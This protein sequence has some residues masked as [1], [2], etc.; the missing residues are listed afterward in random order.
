MNALFHVEQAISLRLQ[1]PVNRDACP[2]SDEPADVLG[3]HDHFCSG[4]LEDMSLLP[5]VF[6]LSFQPVRPKLGRALI[7][8]PL[9]GGLFFVLKAMQRSFQVLQR[10]GEALRFDA[11]LA[12]RLVDKVNGLVRQMAVGDVAAAELH[13]R[14]QR[15]VLDLHFVVRLVLRPERPKHQQGVLVVR[16]LH[17]DGL[18]STLQRTV[19]FDVLPVLG[20]GGGAHALQLAPG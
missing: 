18:E 7:V 19:L 8:G 5:V 10:R 1:E 9:S 12:G 11:F 15:G 17:E 4:V 6:F 3:V 14:L 2:C 13:G 20:L 16:F